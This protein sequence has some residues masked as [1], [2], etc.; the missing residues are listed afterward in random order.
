MSQEFER[1][2]Y[3][4]LSRHNNDNLTDI[5]S[6]LLKIKRTGDGRFVA[7]CPVHNDSSPSLAI[8]QKSDGIILMH[9][10][11]CG[12]GG[13]EIC[14][15]LGIDPASLFPPNDNPRYQK[16]SKDGFSAWHLLN[17]M[18]DNL[19]RLLIISN[20]LKKAD[21]LSNDDREFI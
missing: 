10:F 6:I 11:G 19:I 1:V 20:E 18:Q 8:T 15:A 4:A 3:T 7:C 5:T 16:Q 14:E 17:A 2:N 12:A 13:V 21:V 9:C